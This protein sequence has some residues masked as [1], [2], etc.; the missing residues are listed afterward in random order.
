M[1][2]LRISKINKNVLFIN[3]IDSD[4]RDKSSS[5]AN[6]RSQ[7]HIKVLESLLYSTIKHNDRMLQVM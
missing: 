6:P 1:T 3:N 4:G 2:F 5:D 7:S